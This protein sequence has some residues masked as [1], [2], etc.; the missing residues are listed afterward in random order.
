MNFMWVTDSV[1]ETT[2]HADLVVNFLVSIRKQLNDTYKVYSAHTSYRWQEKD[3]TIKSIT[4]HASIC[5]EYTNPNNNFVFSTPRFV[6]EVVS[7]SSEIDDRKI[8]IYREQEIEE[9]WIVDV[10]KKQIEIYELDYENDVPKYFLWNTI[11]EQNKHELRLCRFPSVKINYEELF[12]NSINDPFYGKGNIAELER[13]V[14]NMEFEKSTFA[15]TLF[16]RV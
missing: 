4:P 16:D 9:C 12:R 1:C 15:L 14:K 3:G 7:D 11:T 10:L 13:E 5:C 6:M 8:D 2:E